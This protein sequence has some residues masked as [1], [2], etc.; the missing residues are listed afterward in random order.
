MS[1][2]NTGAS[3]STTSTAPAVDE[4]T[5]RLVHA[6]L[7]PGFT[8]TSAPPWLLDAL[9]DGLGSVCYFGHNLESPEQTAALSK[10]IHAAGRAV[11]AMDEEGGGVTRLHVCGGSPH[12][13]AAVLGRADDLAL[14]AAVARG[15]ARD[16]RAAGIDLALAPVADVNSDPANPVI[17]VRSFGADPGLV[18]THTAAFVTAM[19]AEGVAACA[20]H[21]PGHGDTKVDSHVGLPVVAVDLETLRSR[22]LVPFAGAVA[23]GV[24]CVMTSHI[25]FP[26]LDS[27]MATVSPAVVALLRD[28]LGFD[29]VIV[30][31]AI[32]ML[33]IAE[34]IGFAESAVRA[35]AAGVDLVCLGNPGLPLTGGTPTDEEEF[36]AVLDAVTRA[37]AEGR[38]PVARLE[39]AAARVHA[40]AD[41]TQGARGARGGDVSEASVTSDVTDANAAAA[42]RALRVRGQVAGSLSGAVRVVDVRR[43]RNVATGRLSDLVA[44]ALLERLPGST[45]EAVFA[46]TATVEGRA[47]QGDLTP[48]EAQDGT[49][50][51]GIPADVVLVGTPGS[52]PAQDAA[53]ARQLA[54]S[55]GAVVVC[56]GWPGTE[57]VLPEAVNA[58]FTHGESLP[59]ARAVAA[60]LTR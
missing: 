55:P 53:L 31:D 52:D 36:R 40:L 46:R 12:V 41:W 59:T 34:T 47:Q 19:Q 56:L 49:A 23:A 45:V 39:E 50:S 20:K 25:V 7:M 9:R 10:R 38:L 8:G 48:G 11:I 57:D 16:V 54:L 27:A 17:G 4:R 24:R 15:I 26:A 32:S 51:P 30:S 29:G 58:V 28:G 21:F 6:V 18:G 13:G 42:R 2:V 33:A 5:R 37:V 3:G 1:S 22:D 60:L 43:R 35:L 44:D 14:T